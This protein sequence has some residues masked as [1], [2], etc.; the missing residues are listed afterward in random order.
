M[1]KNKEKEVEKKETVVVNKAELGALLDRVKTLEAVADKSRVAWY[2][3]TQPKKKELSK[4]TVG[5]YPVKEG[6]DKIIVGWG[7]LVL[8]EMYQDS[9]GAWHERQ[10][11]KLQFEDG[12]SQEVSYIDFVRRRHSV[13][14][15]VISRSLDEETG[16]TTLKVA[17]IGQDKKLDIDST[18]INI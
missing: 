2:E 18:F 16:A 12:T 9:N 5:V 1:D 17:I 11:I 8:N 4:V 14:A 3:G 10:I 15:E 7:Q 6:V 13:P